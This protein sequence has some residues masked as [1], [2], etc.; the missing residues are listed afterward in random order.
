MN[1]VILKP[2]TQPLPHQLE[3]SEFLIKNKAAALFDEQGVGKTKEVI[4]SIIGILEKGDASAALIVCPKTLTYTWKVEISKHSYLKAEVIDGEGRDKGYKFMSPANIFVINYEGIKSNLPIIKML[5]KSRPFILV[6][7]ESQRIKNPETETF[8]S[9]EKIKDYAV[10]KYILSG[11][12]V[13]NSPDDLWAQFYFLDGG[14]TLGRNYKDFKGTFNAKNVDSGMLSDLQKK[15]SPL[16]L[17]RLKTNVLELPEKSYESVY[18]KLSP[19]QNGIYQKLRK[20]LLIEV[21]KVDEKTVLDESRSILKK[22]VR[23]IQ[24]ASNPG[25]VVPDYLEIPA[26]FKALDKIVLEVIARQEK[27][28]IWTS[29]VDNIKALKTRYQDHGSLT[30]YGDIPISNRNRYVEFFQNDSNYRIMIANPAAAREGLTLTAANN[31][32]YLDRNLNM[33]DYLQ[34]QDRIHRISQQKRCRIIKLL[35]EGT[36]DIF[37][38]DK[39]SKKHNI[40]QVIQGDLGSYDDSSYLTKE[41]ILEILN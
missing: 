2:K 39:L 6:L 5:L 35:A 34:S 20:E 41:Q 38:E 19:Q 10:R 7:D 15:I 27:A 13:A 24:I 4:D 11:T 21:M 37:V 29:F 3:A 23:L 14:E 26:K 40:A 9:V 31:A 12:P 17:R 18:I 8:K 30:I 36:I 32:I 33:V 25:L 28:I 16:S 1:S 22:L